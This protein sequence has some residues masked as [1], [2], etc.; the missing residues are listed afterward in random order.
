MLAAKITLAACA[1]ASLAFVGDFLVGLHAADGRNS[2]PIWLANK[3]VSDRVKLA[4]AYTPRAGV[5][6]V[7]S[8]ALAFKAMLTSSQQ[9]TLEQTY[10]TTLARRWSNLPC[11]ANCRNGIALGSLTDEQL[12]AA[13]DVVAAAMGTAANEG[14]DEFN[15]VRWADTVLAAQGGGGGGGG[16]GLSYGEGLYYLAFLNTPTTTGAWMLQFG[17]HHYGANIAYNQGHVV[18]ATPLFEALE[19]LSFTVDST[20]YTP[21]M[22]ERAA[23]AAMLASLSSSELAAAKLSQTFSDV[24]MSPGESNGGNGTFPTAK[25][26]LAVST[27]SDAQKQLVLNAMKPWVQDLEESVA[28]NLLATY[29]SELDGTYIAFTGNGAAGDESSFLVS[30]TNYARIDGPSV[31]IEFACQ[32]G[33]VFSGVHYHTVWRDHVRDYGADLSLTTPLDGSTSAGSLAVTNS[34]SYASGSLSAGAIGTLFGTGLASSTESATSTPLPTTLGGAQ[35]RITDSAGTVFQA[36]LFY[37][38]PTQISFQLSSEAA[39][40]AATVAVLLNSS[41]V[42]QGAVLVESVAPGLFAANASGEGVAAAIAVTTASD[43]SQVAVPLLTLN[44]STSQYDAVPLSLG[45]GSTPVYLLLFGTGF[46]NVASLADVSVTIGGVAATVA[47]AGEQGAFVGLD[48]ANVVI[49][50]GL[51]GSGEVEVVLTASGVASNAVTISIE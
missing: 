27:L 21:L 32:N 48:Q 29:Q 38:S 30:N 14:A 41:T 37:A 45:D 15:Q 36:P 25:V 26:G 46:R 2:N 40:G 4:S 33:V 10:T 42:A 8:K 7:V 16:G 49:P 9:A 1:L 39:A 18:G 51:A 35:V 50:A 17:G 19:P 13:L 43:G 47:Y 11:G 34:A 5:D 6:D 12:A 31:W 24:T 3:A 23:L 22:Q 44:A 28:A 20:T